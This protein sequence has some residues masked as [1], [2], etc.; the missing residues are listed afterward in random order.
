M[1]EA[2]SQPSWADYL[3]GQSLTGYLDFLAF[4]A[5]VVEV[6]LEPGPQRV[7]EVGCGGANLAI[8]L[9]Q[10]GIETVGVD[11]ERDVLNEAR[12]HSR[13]LR[14]HARFLQ[15]DGFVSPF[16]DGAF[17]VSVSQ[18]VLEHFDDELIE[19]FLAESVRVARRTVASMPNVNYPERDFG[20]ER[21]MPAAFWEI[22]AKEALRRAGSFGVGA[23]VTVSDYR[24]R[25]DLRHPV[26]TLTNLLGRRGIFT[27]LVIDRD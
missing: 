27:L 24:R 6:C 14:G 2:V 22:R 3:A 17:D 18:G 1:T 9:S 20:N 21:L 13:S 16:A 23:R 10:L 8:F 25:T 12:R 4:H 15:G 19:S 11:L 26:R 7:V 5:P